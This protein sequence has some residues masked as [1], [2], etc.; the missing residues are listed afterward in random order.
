MEKTK[1]RGGY[2]HRDKRFWADLLSGQAGSGQSVK[3]Y[4]QARGVSPSSFYRWQKLLASDSGPGNGFQAIEIDSGPS[5]GVMVELPGG[6][7]VHFAEWPPVE[8]LH[9]LSGC[10]QSEAGC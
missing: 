5:S 2:T 6:I 7:N 1:A 9:Q 10:F 8:Y 4:C 3:R